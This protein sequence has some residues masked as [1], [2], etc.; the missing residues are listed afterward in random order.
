MR[1]DLALVAALAFLAMVAA[2]LSA[3]V[4]LRAP[5]LVPLVLLLPGYA[6]AANLFAPKTVG[7]AERAVYAIVLSI[8]IAAVGG[9]LI[10]L[11][12]GLG[13]EVWAIFLAGVTLYASLRILVDGRPE[14]LS[15]P[16]SVSWQIPVAA[17]VFVLAGVIASL[18]VVSAGEGLRDAQAKIRFTDFWL[19]PDGRSGAEADNF[20]VGLRSH[21]GQPRSY[22]LELTR[23]AEVL[24]SKDLRLRA[25]EK[26]EKSFAVDVAPRGVPVVAVLS[27]EGVPYRRLDVVPPP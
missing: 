23:G 26:W 25:G 3:P 8:A 24:A 2:L 22:A 9:L 10:Q 21:E 18:A 12:L 20:T 4:W 15:L 16:A 17:L 7:I 19:I 6:V 14:P 27:R 13:R 5:L 11:V 1:R